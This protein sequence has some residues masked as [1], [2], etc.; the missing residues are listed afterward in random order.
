[1]MSNKYYYSFPLQKYIK[2]YNKNTLACLGHIFSVLTPIWHI[3]IA[4][5][6]YLKDLHVSNTVLSVWNFF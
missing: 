1:M 2:K 3:Q 4:L 6:L 5:S